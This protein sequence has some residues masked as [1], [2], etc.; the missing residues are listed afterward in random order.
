MEGHDGCFKYF[1]LYE[2]RRKNE[3]YENN[4]CI[5]FFDMYKLRRRE[6]KI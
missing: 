5:L 4:R 2:E 6:N 3:K 1:L